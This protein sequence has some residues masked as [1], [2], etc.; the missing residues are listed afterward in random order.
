MSNTPSG[1]STANSSRSNSARASPAPSESRGPRRGNRKN[2]NN[3]KRNQPLVTNLARFKQVL[4]VIRQYRPITINGTPTKTIIAQVKAAEVADPEY[5]KRHFPDAGRLLWIQKALADWLR[6]QP[7]APWYLLLMVAPLDPDFPFELESLAMNM[8]IPKDYPNAK[9]RIVVLNEEI[10]RGIAVNIEMGFQNI[11]GQGVDLVNQL[12]ALDENLEQ[13]L[14]QE[15]RATIEFVKAPP[16]SS[17]NTPKP[18]KTP[19]TPLATP[20][21]PLTPE[22][23]TPLVYQLLPEALR[24]RNALVTEF[25]NK[26]NPT[27]YKR[28]AKETKY[29]LRVPV[30][31][32]K[33]PELWQ[34]SVDVIVLVPMAYPET[35]LSLIFASNF[36]T[37]LITKHK[38]GTMPPEQLAALT[39]DYKRYE[40]NVSNNFKLLSATQGSILAGLNQLSNNFDKFWLLPELFEH[41][42]TVVTDFRT[43]T[44]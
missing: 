26:L 15:E 35:P 14:S 24:R 18:E 21:K 13:F 33:A 4:A 7:E 25:T 29:R 44:A 5:F 41:W 17:L 38:A 8:T 37:N 20:L 28:G 11:A 36:S 32:K 40:R 30:S 1:A 27:L 3:Q 34:G 42:Q 39:T 2:R 31:L 43:A 12:K 9:A 22:D 19:P 10:P 6:T 23:T 16:R